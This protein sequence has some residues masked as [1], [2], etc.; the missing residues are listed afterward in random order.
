MKTITKEFIK[1][2]LSYF[3]DNQKYIIDIE[4]MQ[5]MFEEELKLAEK[6]LNN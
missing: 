4:Y 5:T 6:H 1:I 3:E 2:P